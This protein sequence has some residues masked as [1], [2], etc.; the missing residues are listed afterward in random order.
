M[1]LFGPKT[2]DECIKKAKGTRDH[3]EAE[4][5]FLRA[6]AIEPKNLEPLN[7]LSSFLYRAKRF[8]D[9][10]KYTAKALL[11]DP[12]NSEALCTAGACYWAK[13]ESQLA[14][15]HYE[16][17]L[18]FKHEFDVAWYNL[19]LAFFDVGDFTNSVRAYREAV[20]IKPDYGRGKAW[21]NLGNAYLKLREF[22]SAIACH[23]ESL[24]YAPDDPIT[25]YN[26]GRV[27]AEKGNLSEA[28]I[29]YQQCLTNDP[30]NTNAIYNMAMI[31]YKTGDYV[32]S[33]ELFNSAI[34]LGDLQAG[35]M[36]ERL[37]PFFRKAFGGG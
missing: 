1:S 22:E 16:K 34:E 8:D 32:R 37:A 18:K 11:H 6:I 20:R 24:H 35:M 23:K 19:G 15:E 36:L 3:Q 17:A 2:A 5:W 29:H 13:N 27:F 7:E 14:I 4:K 28:M 30:Q 21:S 9:S 10:L 12:N 25:H 26:L 31:C 33:I